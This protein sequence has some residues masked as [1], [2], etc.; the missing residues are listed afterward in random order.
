M[1]RA[2]QQHRVHMHAPGSEFDATQGERKHRT[3]ATRAVIGCSTAQRKDF[4]RGQVM[5]RVMRNVSQQRKVAHELEQRAR[6]V[7]VKSRT[8]LVNKYVVVRLV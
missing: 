5:V 8:L 7:S 2:G 4:I 1:A 3:E 6:A